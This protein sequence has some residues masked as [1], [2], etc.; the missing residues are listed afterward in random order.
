VGETDEMLPIWSSDG[1]Y[2]IYQRRPNQGNSPWETWAEPLFGDHKAFPVVQ[3]PQFLNADPALSPDGKWI[4][5]DSN[6]FGRLE[7]FLTAFLRGGGKWQ[8]ST[9]GGTCPRW[10]ADGRELVYMSLD[11]K[12]MSAEILEQGSTLVIGKVQ[13]LFQANPVPRA[14][15]CM[16]DVAPDG[17]KFVVV[18]L[19]V[20]QGSQPL[21]LVVNWSLLLK[22]Q[23][24]P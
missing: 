7:V 20:E 24:Q 17:K 23:R 6:E 16:Y 18:T 11:N 4:A 2:L 14:P 8:V 12:V 13:T 9:S 5:Y 10:R 3:N 21:T 19:A 22:R 1:R 15:E